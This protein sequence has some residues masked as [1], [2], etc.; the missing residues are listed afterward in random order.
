MEHASWALWCAW[1]NGALAL[2]TFSAS[3]T[4]WFKRL[5]RPAA[6]LTISA[7]L[8]SDT[9]LGTLGGQPKLLFISLL[10]L[11]F[12]TSS[13]LPWSRRVQVG[14]NLLCVAG[15]LIQSWWVP[16]LDGLGAYKLL[17]IV[18]AAAL[19]YFTCYVRDRFIL[20]YE[21]S[22]RIIRESEAALRQLFDA[23][24]DGITLIDLATRRI[25]DVN[26]H[27]LKI[28]GFRREEVIGKTTA[29]LDVWTDP[30]MEQ[31]FVRRI[32]AENGV[33]NV[34][35]TFRAKDGTLIPCLL[36]S[37][38]VAIR[39]QPCVM[40]LARDI[41]DLRRS[42]A[43]LRESEEKFRLIFESSRDSIMLNRISDLRIFEFNEY[44][45]RLTG[46]TREEAIGRTPEELGLWAMPEQR[47]NFLQT[48]RR[49]G[50]IDAYEM[51]MRTR[52]GAEVPVLLSAVTVKLAKED[53]YFAMARDI[54][55]LREAEHKIRE[56][57]ATQRRIFNASVDWMSI[58]D[59]ATGDYMDINDSFAR[60]TGYSREEL[61]GSSFFKLG[62]WPDELQWQ[63][64]IDQLILNGE[65]RN[66]PATFKMK[67]GR[68]VSALLSAV[69]CELWGKV[70]CI[71]SARDVTELNLAQEK[72]RRSEE[73]FRKIFDASLD[74]MGIVDILTG[75]Y[76]DINPEFIRASGYSREEIIG[77]DGD[78]LNQWVN[79]EQR[80]QFERALFQKREVR[81]M[82]ADFR[83][84][85]GS[86]TTSLA[87][88]VL[89][90]LGG[91]LC[92]I[93]V[94]RDI[95]ELKAAE[96]K[97][98]KNETM[99]RAML[100]S[101]LDNVAL[102]DLTNETILEVNNEMARSMG[103]TREEIV[104]KH[105]DDLVPS[106]DPVR[107]E[108]FF[109]L[110]A[111]GHEI[112][113]FELNVS[114][115]EGRRTFPALISASM[116]RLEGRPCALSVAR[117]ITDLAAAREAA[118]AASQAKSEFLSTMSHEIR[119][120]M[121]A[122]LG[123]ADLMGES[124][125][126][127][128]Q[129][130]YLDT[131]LSNGNALLELINSILDLAKVESGRLNLEAVEFDLGELTEHAADTLAVRAHEK[132][133]ELSVRFA[134][135]LPPM[136]LGDPYRLRQILTNLIGNAIKFTRKG[137]IAV[138]VARNPEASVPGNLLFQV[139]DTGI[140]I[141]PEKIESIFSIFTQ[142]DTSTTRKFGGSGLGLAIVQRLVG[143]MGGQVW[144]ESEVGKGSDFSFTAH[145]QA[146][147]NSLRATWP[148]DDLHV[149]GLRAL[150]AQENPTARAIVAD[151]AA[152]QRHSRHR[153]GIG[154]RSA[155]GARCDS[156]RGGA[157]RSD[158]G[159]LWNPIDR[160]RRRAPANH[161]GRTCAAH[162]HDQFASGGG[163]AASN[164]KAG[165]PILLHQ[166][167]QAA[168]SLCGDRA[169]A[170][171]GSGRSLAAPGATRAFGFESGGGAKKSKPGDRP[172]RAANSAGGRFA[173]QSSADSRLHE[174]NALRPH[175]GGE[176]SDRGRAFR[177]CALRPGADGYPD[178]SA[179]R[180]QCGARDSQVGG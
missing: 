169:G 76:V 165:R 14:F 15:W 168:R 32:R 172:A 72:L 140:G 4:R 82:E 10:L 26:A 137:E 2:T 79:P 99:L 31:E 39:G 13:I 164:A 126:N 37:V 176:R 101:S 118:L 22:E 127:S 141:A 170:G 154:R 81:N 159:R 12:G 144:V 25:Q 3:F 100:D 53:C 90:E 89:A 103:Y 152:P 122:I 136:L 52:A 27:F 114:S 105:F 54:S 98:R 179:R 131:I 175:R 42:Q 35:I 166:A 123:M 21:A 20:S 75:S 51:S 77:S 163:R 49:Q 112:R 5:W 7:L 50:Y 125:L 162:P 80:A 65:V 23:N 66:H 91:K 121:N 41:S 97:L 28:S 11:M 24:T 34:E 57:D 106:A 133:V 74:A 167:G 63:D 120:P 59:M 30:A 109:A 62:L 177:R 84:K 132:G 171:R 117:D 155:R 67:D 174:E 142:A 18:T 180:L 87:S 73:T 78:A 45:V 111:Q 116:L 93:G 150:V 94:T 143:L 61:I 9:V 148:T 56:S 88:A 113:N 40:T 17:G 102:I 161:S 96:R 85:D 146:V 92:C 36:S 124:E 178:A 71:S 46:F 151:L 149:A 134:P 19:S 147:E 157:L 8:A 86:I 160:R 158:A 6:F 107:Q 44:F 69:Q 110:L 64:F 16:S 156:S 70:C 130:R 139:R 129:R 1:F 115:R 119:T 43:A 83:L 55:H 128:E 104:G 33:N 38:I 95:S 108:K 173:R 153:G 48:L 68:L 47:A 58:V 135:D 138:S 29:E 60:A 145:L